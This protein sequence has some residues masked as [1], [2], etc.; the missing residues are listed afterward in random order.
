MVVYY[1]REQLYAIW[2]SKAF[3]KEYEKCKLVN[4]S[5]IDI[6]LN[7]NKKDFQLSELSDELKT[8]KNNLNK[9]SISNI[10]K[11]KSEISNIVTDDILE[12]CITIIIDK[13]INEPSYIDLYVIA[14]KKILD[15]N[16]LDIRY[17]INDKIKTI[18]TAI[19]DDDELSEYDTLCNINKRLDNSVGLCI[20]IVKL[21][22]NFIIENYIKNTI[23]RFLST[24]D[25]SNTEL[26]DKSITS[27]YTIFTLLDPRFIIVY[28][29]KL[30][31]IWNQDI[32]KKNKFKIMDIFDLKK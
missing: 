25:I 20:L 10:K 6:L 3:K 15:K 31:E 14:L 16:V 18:F 5:K 29:D 32:G 30:Q 22:Q 17:I 7:I 11:M 27:L 9:L 2:N 1:S 28:E 24:L 23:D 12:E 26:C 13:C 4:K 19:I 8:F 21:E